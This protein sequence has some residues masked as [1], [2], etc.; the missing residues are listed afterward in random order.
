MCSA[1]THR[2]CVASM[3]SSVIGACARKVYLFPHTGQVLVKRLNQVHN[4]TL[5]ERESAYLQAVA[6]V[7]QGGDVELFT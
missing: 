2:K 7:S 6:Q 4:H 3:T 1:S 5:L